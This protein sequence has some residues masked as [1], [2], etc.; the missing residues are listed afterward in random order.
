MSS[1]EKQ[2]ILSTNCTISSSNP[3][4][5][6]SPD[7]EL[8]TVIPTYSAMQFSTIFISAITVIASVHSASIPALDASAPS[9]VALEARSYNDPNSGSNL[10][11]RSPGYG[12]SSGFNHQMGGWGGG[13]HWV[14]PQMQFVHQ[15]MF[16]QQQFIHSQQSWY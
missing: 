8:A 2:K 14:Q 9:Q 1:L 12:H 3:N 11:K 7:Q 16:P 6:I 5:Q 10:E 4:Q 13:S 15:Q